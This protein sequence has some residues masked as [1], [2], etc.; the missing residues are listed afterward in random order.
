MCL[1]V[2]IF[3]DCYIVTSYLGWYFMQDILLFYCE[4][5]T[6]VGHGGVKSDR[7]NIRHTIVSD[8]AMLV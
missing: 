1:E 5:V 3:Q 4:L 6:K 7:L 8:E 2:H